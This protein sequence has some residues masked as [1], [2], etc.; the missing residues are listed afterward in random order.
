M[1]KKIT[2]NEKVTRKITEV[3]SADNY[4]TK[5]TTENISLAINKL[6]GELD[7]VKTVNERVFYF[8]SA[9]V[10]FIIDSE[11]VHFENGDVLYLAK[12]TEY[13]AMG[14]FEAVV[15]NSPAF[16]VIKE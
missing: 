9:N 12:N 15:I 7:L 13:S 10:D 11:K 1:Y 4:L 6:S 2:K 3:H 14:D 8:I 16:G 5:E